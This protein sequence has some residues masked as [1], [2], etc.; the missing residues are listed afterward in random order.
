ME[1]SRDSIIS[2]K[3]SSGKIPPSSVGVAAPS[4]NCLGC[5]EEALAERSSFVAPNS[6]VISFLGFFLW[7][8][9]EVTDGVFASA[10][11]VSVAPL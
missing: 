1:W 10:L 5:L 7:T 3:F 2:S 8:G 9:V 11:T 6:L 4:C